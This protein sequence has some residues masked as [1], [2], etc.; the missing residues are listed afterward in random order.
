MEDPNSLEAEKEWN[1]FQQMLFARTSFADNKEVSEQMKA[2][3]EEFDNWRKRD[4]HNKGQ[5]LKMTRL[6]AYACRDSMKDSYIRTLNL[7]GPRWG[8]LFHARNQHEG[9]PP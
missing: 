1:H 2:F 3:Q 9:L 8:G 5:I 6:L 4:K 7:E